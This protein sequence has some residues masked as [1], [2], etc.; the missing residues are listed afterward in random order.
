MIHGKR[1]A[2]QRR[3]V[4]RAM[5]TGL[6]DFHE[7]RYQVP[8]WRGEELAYEILRA[9]D[10]GSRYESAWLHCTRGFNQAR[11]WQSRGQTERNNMDSVICRID[12][13]A[14][15]EWALR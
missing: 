11:I 7:D 8:E 3:Y 15:E 10:T 2:P 4:Y 13:L 1:V 6:R 9:V 14:V 12:V 5:T